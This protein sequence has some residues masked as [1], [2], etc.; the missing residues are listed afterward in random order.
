MEELAKLPWPSDAVG[1]ELRLDSIR[2]TFDFLFQ[3]ERIA[4]EELASRTAHA[5]L[6]LVHQLPER[7]DLS[8]PN[9]TFELVQTLQLIL[10]I[11]TD[12]DRSDEIFALQQAIINKVPL[13]SI[14][15]EHV[16][17]HLEAISVA[18][19]SAWQHGRRDQSLALARQAVEVARKAQDVPNDAVIVRATEFDQLVRLANLLEEAGHADELKGV[20]KKIVELGVQLQ[21]TSGA[22]AARNRQWERHRSRQS[23]DGLK[24]GEDP[25]KL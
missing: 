9:V 10:G 6:S 24:P 14:K 2:S 16:K 7:A 12:S 13:E 8:D 17:K 20:E 15:F 3:P 21:E 19:D 25:F 11:A 22:S 18:V 4:N 1:K 5:A 23:G